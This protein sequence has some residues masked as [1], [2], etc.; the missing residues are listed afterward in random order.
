MATSPIEC[1]AAGRQPSRM[2][3][4]AG[5]DNPG[6]CEEGS[7]RDTAIAREQ[8]NALGLVGPAA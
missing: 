8:L 4:S 1:L 5:L 2:P 3:I 6:H 7:P